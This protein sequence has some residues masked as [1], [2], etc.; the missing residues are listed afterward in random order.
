MPALDL[1]TLFKVILNL[2]IL[3]PIGKAPRKGREHN[4]SIDRLVTKSFRCPPPPSKHPNRVKN[5]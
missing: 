1:T 3:L 4:Q 2:H 5:T